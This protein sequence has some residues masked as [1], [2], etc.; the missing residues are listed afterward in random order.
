MKR[1]WNIINSQVYSLATYFDGRINMNICTY[2]MA[3]SMKPK[4]YAI[5]I[6]YNTL[7]HQFLL[8]SEFSVLQILSSSN[9]GIVK[10]LGK[11][12]GHKH[13]K[14]KYLKNRNLLTLWNNY[15]VLENAAGYVELEK[16]ES[17]N[18][19]GDHELFLFKTK[20]FKTIS[21]NTLMFQDLVQK[22]I[23]L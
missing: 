14:Q 23:I 15:Q 19:G 2:V 3:V 7:S 22:G 1:P 16:T 10:Y 17:K 12:S 9:I 18:F 8:R 6:D 11:K 13:N 20:S 4:M 21:N 5:A